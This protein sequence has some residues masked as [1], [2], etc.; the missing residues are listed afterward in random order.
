MCD[1]CE[2]EVIALYLKDVCLYNEPPPGKKQERLGP[3]LE[4]KVNTEKAC[5]YRILPAWKQTQ[6]P[7]A[8]P[9]VLTL[10]SFPEECPPSLAADTQDQEAENDSRG[11]VHPATER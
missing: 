7:L 2:E 4:K 11:K 1:V 10:T 9:L 3:E 5:G 6:P 8:H